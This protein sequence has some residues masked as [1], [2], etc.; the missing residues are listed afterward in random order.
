MGEITEWI[1]QAREGDAAAGERLYSAV[2]EDLRRLAGRVL[3]GRR[4]GARP[5][6]LVHEAYARLARPAALGV[7]DRRHFFAVAA[8][9][10]RQI[11]VDRA[12]G[13]GRVKRG[14]E[15]RLVSLDDVDE[16]ALAAGDADALAL[17]RALARLSAVDGPL[18]ELV[19]LR[20][21]G[22]LEL[23]EIAALQGRSERSLK[24]DW[25]KARAFLHAQ[26]ADGPVDE[27]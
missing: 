18:A 26:L 15:H 16:P 24:R 5:T 23:E 6:S 13:L 27:G 11:V 7:T 21:F 9:A 14:G 3:G 1:Q 12:R 8:R 10:M 22:G 4:D 17:D 25:R 20:F 2:Y 19:E